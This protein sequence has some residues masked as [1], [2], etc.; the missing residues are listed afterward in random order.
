[1][2]FPSIENQIGCPD[3]SASVGGKRASGTTHD[4]DKE[5]CVNNFVE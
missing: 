2:A 5:E 4:I 3:R 1:M